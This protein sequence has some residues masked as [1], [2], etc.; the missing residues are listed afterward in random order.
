MAGYLMKA[1]HPEESENSKLVPNESEADPEN[2][3]PKA[4]PHSIR[5]ILLKL[6]NA[7]KYLL[8]YRC[9]K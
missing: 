5:N 3:E 4:A 9:G 2:S 7:G 1:L 8:G 6:K